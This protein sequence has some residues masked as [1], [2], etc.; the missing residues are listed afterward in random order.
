[1]PIIAIILILVCAYVLGRADKEEC[2]GRIG[3]IW[4]DMRPLSLRK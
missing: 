4:K 1:M 3:E 2:L